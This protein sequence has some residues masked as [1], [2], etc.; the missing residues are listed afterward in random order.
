VEFLLLSPPERSLTPLPP[1]LPLTLPQLNESLVDIIFDVFDSDNSG[2]L[3]NDEF[4]SVMH[5]RRFH[6]AGRRRLLCH[7]ISLPPPHVCVCVCVSQECGRSHT[8][9]L[10]PSSSLPSYV[11]PQALLFRAHSIRTPGFVCSCKSVRAANNG[12]PLHRPCRNIDVGRFIGCCRS[13]FE[14]N[15]TLS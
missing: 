7:N 9:T 11:V 1:L 2:T 8:N 6:G 15:L 5:V 12:S 14:N 13:C 10:K 3:E 4:I